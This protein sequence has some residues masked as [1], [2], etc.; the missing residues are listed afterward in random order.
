M[1][2][3]D[4]IVIADRGFPAASNANILLRY[5]GHSIPDLLDA[6][7]SLFPLDQTENPVHL[8][9]IPA[10]IDLY[11]ENWAKYR[12]IIDMYNDR[13]IEFQ[14]LCKPDFYTRSRMAYAII[15]TGDKG[16]FSN[17]ILRKGIFDI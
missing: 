7:L 6:I 15:A 8:M 3:G 13:H 10:E 9:E 12:S 2:H 1:G 17:I 16:R 4:E 5:D 14:F 11:P